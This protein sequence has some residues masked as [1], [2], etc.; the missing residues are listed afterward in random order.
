MSEATRLFIGR[1]RAVNAVERMEPL[2]ISGRERG[3]LL[4]ARGFAQVRSD[5]GISDPS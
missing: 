5:Y 3:Q 4:T 2:R 1:T